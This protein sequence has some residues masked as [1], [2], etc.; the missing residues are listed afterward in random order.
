[1]APLNVSWEQARYWGMIGT[2]GIGSGLFFAIDGDHTLG[3][4]ESRSGRFLDRRDYCKLH[5]ISHY[6]KVLLGPTFQTILIGKVGADP[7][8]LRL[9]EEM[10]E[11]GLDTRYVQVCPGKQTMFSVCFTYPDGSGGN[12]TAGDS[13]CNEVGPANIGQAE[14]E[15]A[16]YQGRG[17]A[18]A[19]PE[20][21]LE[22]RQALLSLA[23][24]YDFFRVGS[25]ISGEIPSAIRLGLFHMLDLLALNIDEAAMA[26]GLSS[27]DQRPED[28]VAA[29]VERLA[30]TYPALKLSLTAGKH[31]SW[32]WD[33]SRLAQK[34]AYPAPI[35][36][37]AGAGDAHIAGMIAGQVAGLS[38]AQS[39]E[40]GGLVAS[41]S[42]TSPH[43]IAPGINR[44]ALYQFASEGK[45]QLEGAVLKLISE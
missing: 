11:T 25:F 29:T 14:S 34:P 36:S 17:V 45:I 13:V 22:A 30:R 32:T 2:G 42:I 35:V 5:I 8:G 31:G 6:V 4:E 33:G 15:M 9:M 44:E 39:Q 43:T 10:A 20:V 18:L 7:A 27:E 23:T 1:M 41:L 3:R 12:L 38:L 40:L 24:R 26:A 21:P 19:A 16:R 37:T 28:I